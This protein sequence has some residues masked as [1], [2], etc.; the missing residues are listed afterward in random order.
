VRESD[1]VRSAFIQSWYGIRW[2]QTDAFDLVIDTSK[3]QPD[4]AVIA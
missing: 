4:V 1:K 3:V 2:D